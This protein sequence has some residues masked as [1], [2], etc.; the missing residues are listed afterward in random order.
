MIVAPIANR[1]INPSRNAGNPGK[2]S[3]R[4]AS[5]GGTATI[6]RDPRHTPPSLRTT[7]PPSPCSIDRT[8]A[9]NTTPAPP[10][11]NP[12][13]NRIDNACAP[14]TNRDS[15]APPTTPV[16]LSNPPPVRR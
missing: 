2:Y 15:C 7:T 5:A 11:T 1:C 13:A 4:P 14:S 6:T 8:A 12:A 9:P 10:E 16:K 3:I